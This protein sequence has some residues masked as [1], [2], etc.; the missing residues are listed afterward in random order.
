[1]KQMLFDICETLGPLVHSSVLKR[2]ILALIHAIKVKKKII[3]YITSLSTV[4][5]LRYFDHVSEIKQTYKISA[6][7]NILHSLKKQH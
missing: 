3:K 2:I 6:G 7:T 1:M 4:Q 5:N